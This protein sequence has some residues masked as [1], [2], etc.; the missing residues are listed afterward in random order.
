VQPEKQRS[1]ILIE[2][3]GSDL[4]GAVEHIM[5]TLAPRT[6]AGARV[7]IKPNMVGPSAPELGH[8][9]HPEL[10]RAVVRSCLDRNGKVW[11]GD[12][13]GGINRSSRNVAEI[14]GILDASEGCFTSISNR[15]V[16]K[17]GS[18]TGFQLIISKAVLE[19]D[20][21]I[22]L[23][24][25]KTHASMMISGSLKN[26]F[27]YVA[28][29]CKARLHL[30][31]RNTENVA[32]VICD[33][34]QVRPPDLHMVDAITAI[35]GNGPCHAGQLRQV[36]KLLGGTDPLALDGVIAHMMGVDPAPFPI[37]KEA[38]SRGL[39]RLNRDETE[40]LGELARI[41]DF[42]MPATFYAARL[43]EKT[44]AEFRKHYPRG[45]M[46][47]RIEI[48]PERKA[49]KCIACGDCALNCPAEAITMEPEFHISETCIACYCCVE[50][51]PEG[52]ME[53]PDVEVFR[54]Y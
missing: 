30:Q 13:P 26:I 29:A 15:V 33:V 9:T 8:T 35:E 10:V 51:C 31:A 24:I 38:L 44:R 23:P 22:S 6:F 42:K 36:G 21:I 2:K 41:P 4:R 34:H 19:S 20:Y 7:L 25:F 53:V 48:K 14:T 1:R 50:L 39:G 54:H 37:Q 27:G 32:K 46:E 12:N 52:A 3:I 16:E 28:G 5:A 47:T 45:M 43:D 18:E 11:V 17:T 49:E 40:I